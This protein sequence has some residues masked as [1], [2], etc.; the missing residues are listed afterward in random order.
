MSDLDLFRGL[1]IANLSAEGATAM[2]QR[3]I[4]TLK[5]L[6]ELT[7]E[8]RTQWTQH[9]LSLLRMAVGVKRGVSI[10]EA[11]TLWL[12]K[13]NWNELDLDFRKQ[14]GLQFETFA[15]K[16]TGG[17][18]SIDTIE[19]YMRAAKV[20]IED[21]YTPGV[22]IKIPER[23]ERGEP[24]MGE[25]NRPIMREVSWDPTRTDISKLVLLTPLAR[26]RD[27]DNQPK[28][29]ALAM[30][31]GATVSQLRMA[32]YSPEGD[33]PDYN[34]RFRLEGPL[35]VVVQNGRS[36]PIGEFYF[37]DD[38]DLAQQGINRILRMLNVSTDEKIL[39]AMKQRSDLNLVY[40]VDDEEEGV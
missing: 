22:P 17:E 16:E 19:N 7:E 26:S 9:M 27:L 34:L 29:L 38:D 12:F 2:V 32:L 31:P 14:Y 1:N 6:P 24:V 18:L 8:N 39:L 33:G 5:S 30:D 13:K 20:F 11:H 40:F 3:I 15:L 36:A 35:L 21:N 10:I 25:D 23:D 28:L 4:S 37:N